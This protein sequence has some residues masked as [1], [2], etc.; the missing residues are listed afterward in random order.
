MPRS[1]AAVATLGLVVI[2]ALLAFILVDWNALKAPIERRVSARTG[3]P[4]TI[5]GDLRVSIA[6]RLWVT[7]EDVQVA[8]AAGASASGRFTART[9]DRRAVVARAPDRQAGPA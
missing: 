7:A 6:R 4:L 8:S 5:G 2:G 9:G 3:H 1:L